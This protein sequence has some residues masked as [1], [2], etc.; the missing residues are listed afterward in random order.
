MRA[1]YFL[2][3]SV[4]AMMAIARRISATV[5]VALL[6][7]VSGVASAQSAYQPEFSLDIVSANTSTADG[8]T[9]RLDV[10]TSIPYGNLRF[11]ARTGGF[12]ASYNVTLDLYSVDDRGRQQGLITSRTFERQVGVEGYDATLSA[13]TFD[14]AVQTLD[15]P[16]GR[17]AVTVA[18]EDGASNRTFSRE[19]AVVVRGAVRGIAI[20][21]P[22]LLDDYEPGSRTVLPNVGAAI[23]TEQEAFTV[24]YEIVTPGPTKLNVSYIVTEKNRVRDRPSFS[25]LLGLAPR[26]R[27]DLGSPVA[28]IES[29]DLVAGMNPAAF[30]ISTDDIKVGDYLLT[31]R[32]ETETGELVAETE[33]SFSVRWMGLEGQIADLDQAIAQLRYVARDRDLRDIRAAET[34]EEKLRAFQ[35]FWNRFDPTP[36]TSRNERME[37]YYFRVAFA[38]ERYSRLRDSGWRT[39]RGEV[40]IRFGEPD[41]VEEHPFNYGTQPYQIWT[42][43]RSSRRFIFVDNTGTGDFELLVPIWDDRTRL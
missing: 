11:L 34:G 32:L 23:S 42:Y 22:L 20:S 1:R 19:T 2:S 31:V 25:A 10:Y 15:V 8:V 24:F 17:Y 21:D 33:K 16:V 4:R 35:E 30:R 40:F 9:P 41:N 5:A 6:L 28:T 36:G 26:Q 38:N 39:D 13:E 27:A 14:R 18:V 3:P 29:L 7:V 37:E 43:Y 12:E